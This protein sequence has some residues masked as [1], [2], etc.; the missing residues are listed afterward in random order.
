MKWISHFL[1][2]SWYESYRARPSV[3]G[4]RRDWQWKYM[5]SVWSQQLL[6]QSLQRVFFGKRAPGLES[7]EN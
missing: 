4:L 7:V 6:I 5:G 2:L 1:Q 3:W